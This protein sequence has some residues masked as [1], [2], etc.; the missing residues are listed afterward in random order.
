MVADDHIVAPSTHNKSAYHFDPLVIMLFTH[1]I[2]HANNSYCH[3]LILL[4]CVR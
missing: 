3:K 4:I 1:K 2:Y